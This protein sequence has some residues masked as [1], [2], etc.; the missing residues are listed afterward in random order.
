MIRYV[1]LLKTILCDGSLIIISM[2]TQPDTGSDIRPSYDLIGKKDAI[3]RH[4]RSYES[5]GLSV[6]DSCYGGFHGYHDG[7]PTG[8]TTVLEVAGLLEIKLEVCCGST[9]VPEIT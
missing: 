9:T 2:A 8:I 1:R 3:I 5:S 4:P 7:S 6:Q